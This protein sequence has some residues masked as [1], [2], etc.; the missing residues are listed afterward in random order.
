MTAAAARNNVA[1]VGCDLYVQRLGR[2]DGRRRNASQSAGRW[3]HRTPGIRRAVAGWKRITDAVH[4]SAAPL[5]SLWL[6][7]V[8]IRLR[9]AP[10]AVG[11][12]RSK[13]K[14]HQQ[15]GQDPDPALETSK[16]A[17]S[18]AIPHSAENAKAAGFD[19]V[20]S[21]AGGLLDQFLRDGAN[22]HTDAMVAIVNRALAAGLPKR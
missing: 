1:T 11:G 13:A 3:L 6:G 19:G 9:C 17:A 5:R 7:R 8:C 10:V 2:P 15:Q 12:C 22:Q 21:S 20:S 4:R 14:H 18:C 16:S